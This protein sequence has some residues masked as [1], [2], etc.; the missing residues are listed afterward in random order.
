MRKTYTTSLNLSN[1]L[2]A[3]LIV[4]FSFEIYDFPL[5]AKYDWENLQGGTEMDMDD[6][7]LQRGH[8]AGCT[9]KTV[10]FA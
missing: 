4:H 2:N 6:N 5:I 8:R 3:P 7:I 1:V 9:A 10:C